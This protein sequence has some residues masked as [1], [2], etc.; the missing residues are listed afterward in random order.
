[1]DEQAARQRLMEYLDFLRRADIG[2]WPYS[3]WL[4]DN[5]KFLELQN[6][7]W[8]AIN[9][10]LQSQGVLLKGKHSKQAQGQAA[11]VTSSTGHKQHRVMHSSTGSGLVF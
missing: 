9:P 6:G 7:D 11:Q 8:L 10:V 2:Y 5:P 1:M 4:T 3:N